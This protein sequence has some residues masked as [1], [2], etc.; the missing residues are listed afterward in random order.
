VKITKV[1]LMCSRVGVGERLFEDGLI[2]EELI[3]K[4][5]PHGI[6]KEWLNIDESLHNWVTCAVGDSENK[7]PRRR[8]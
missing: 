8:Q 6:K 5:G 4:K 7:G 3:T 2:I 1:F